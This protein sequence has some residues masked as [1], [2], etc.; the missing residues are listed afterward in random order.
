MFLS[1]W[2]SGDGKA[3]SVR[4]H[5]RPVAGKRALSK[6]AGSEIYGQETTAFR[7]RNNYPTTSFFAASLVLADWLRVIS[8]NVSSRSECTSRNWFTSTPE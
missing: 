1:G 4:V 3:L 8:R 5:T 6:S 7:R 2:A